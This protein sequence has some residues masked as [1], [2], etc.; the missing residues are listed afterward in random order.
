M[1]YIWDDIN[2]DYPSEVLNEIDQIESEY[3][4]RNETV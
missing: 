1:D 2:V 3:A 4:R